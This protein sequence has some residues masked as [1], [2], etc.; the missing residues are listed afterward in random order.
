[1][2]LSWDLGVS[3][4]ATAPARPYLHLSVAPALGREE[5]Q[6]R[7]EKESSIKNK[8]IFSSPTSR[9]YQVI[10][11][12]RAKSVHFPRY[13]PL[14]QA[15]ALQY[16]PPH[17]RDGQCAVLDGLTQ[18]CLLFLPH[19]TWATGFSAGPTPNL[20]LPSPTT[21]HNALFNVPSTTASIAATNTVLSSHIQA[22]SLHESFSVHYHYQ[23]SGL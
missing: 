1:M 7:T 23:T 15:K 11:P 3:S 6:S 21:S 5:N 14:C 13:F 9:T 12:G 20:L 10:A 8:T 16:P 18:L 22:W 4:S 2:I 19:A 17:N